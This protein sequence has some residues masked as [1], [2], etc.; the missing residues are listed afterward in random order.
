MATQARGF[1]ANQYAELA[2]LTAPTAVFSIQDKVFTTL[3]GN[4]CFPSS[5]NSVDVAQIDPTVA[6]SLDRAIN[7]YGVVGHLTCQ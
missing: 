5:E 7:S 4:G 1:A 3:I 6:K 2:T